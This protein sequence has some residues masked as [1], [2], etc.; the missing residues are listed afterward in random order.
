MANTCFICKDNFNEIYKICQCEDSL[1]CGDCLTISN[2]QHMNICPICR[3]PLNI[4]YIRDKYKY[5]KLIIPTIVINLLA[6]TMPLIFP[7][8]NLGYNY[9]NSA[10]VLF[11]LS[12]YCVLI[13]QPYISYKISKEYFI[14]Y[15][16]YLF[17][18]TLFFTITMPLIYLANLDTRENM[19]ILLFLMPYFALPSLMLLVIDL[20][21]R[22]NNF[23]IYLDKKTLTKQIQFNKIVNI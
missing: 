13:L 21:E 4:K 18:K 11:S 23:K 1:I 7:I 8:I 15:N 2:A 9:S 14:K 5:C 6:F 3:R 10:V 19:Y 20:L 22:K 12:L 16:K 17:Y